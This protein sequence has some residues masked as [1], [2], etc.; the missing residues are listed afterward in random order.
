[1]SANEHVTLAILW[2]RWNGQRGTEK[3]VVRVMQ[4]LSVDVLRRMLSER[5][6]QVHG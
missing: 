2:C 1:M 3:Q 5:G 4:H 6:V